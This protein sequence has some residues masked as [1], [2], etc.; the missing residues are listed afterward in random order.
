MSK[1]PQARSTRFLPHLLALSC[2]S[3]LAFSLNVALVRA[4]PGTHA[5]GT[6][7]FDRQLEPI[8]DSYLKIGDALSSNSLAGVPVLAKSIGTQAATID[9]SSVTGEHAAHYKDVPTNLQKAAQ[10]LSQ[11]KTLD[12][13]RASFKKLSMP[14]VMWVTMSKPKDIDVLYCSMAKGSWVQKHGKVRNP[15]YGAEMLDCGEVVGGERHAAQK[16]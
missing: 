9:A 6:Q 14:M 12:E 10:T 16:R 15:Y 8:L 11:A 1:H 3:V 2:V 13:A 4:E 7:R 5:T